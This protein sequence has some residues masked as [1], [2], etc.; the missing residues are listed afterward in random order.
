MLWMGTREELFPSSI[1]VT[2]KR[3]SF[4]I[5]KEFQQDCSGLKYS[6]LIIL[7][8]NETNEL[9][10]LHDDWHA[11][12]H[13]TTKGSGSFFDGHLKSYRI[14]ARFPQQAVVFPSVFFFPLLSRDRSRFVDR[15]KRPQTD[16]TP[17]TNY[18]TTPEKIFQKI[19]NQ[20]SALK[21]RDRELAE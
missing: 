10:N 19:I 2:A 3:F 20:D 13:Y 14:A 9:R 8:T 21:N 16:N 6:W 5:K 11:R 1:E 4:F 12:N 7:R 18:Q 15:C 17:P